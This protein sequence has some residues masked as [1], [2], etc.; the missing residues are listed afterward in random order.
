MLAIVIAMIAGALILQV[1][2][3]IAGNMDNNFGGITSA[4]SDTPNTATASSSVTGYPAT[5][6]IDGNSTSYWES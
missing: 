5:N 3:S 1:A 6:A 2:I 4:Q